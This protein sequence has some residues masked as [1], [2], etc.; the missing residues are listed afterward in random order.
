MPL[1]D[2]NLPSICLFPGKAIPP[3]T[4]SSGFGANSACPEGCWQPLSAERLTESRGREPVSLGTSCSPWQHAFPQKLLTTQCLPVK[5]CLLA[6]CSQ[7]HSRSAWN[8]LFQFRV[9][10]HY[11]TNSLRAGKPAAY[12]WLPWRLSLSWDKGCW[13]ENQ[14]W[15][16]W[17]IRHCVKTTGF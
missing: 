5:D 8:V 10:Y 13:L 3:S 4:S 9:G 14:K 6:S 2:N 16:I 17:E 15:N 7:G 1:Q 12:T 11:P